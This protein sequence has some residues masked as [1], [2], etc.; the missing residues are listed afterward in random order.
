MNS[1]RKRNSLSNEH[2]L[3]LK[4]P[5]EVVLLHENVFIFL[6]KFMCFHFAMARPV[7]DRE[8]NLLV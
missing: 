3:W 6:T 2:V 7:I 8:K 5:D 1:K 4:D